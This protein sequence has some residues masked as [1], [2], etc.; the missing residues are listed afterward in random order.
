MAR[1]PG[2]QEILTLHEVAAYLR[3]HRSTIYRM[4]QNGQLPGAFRVGTDWRITRYALDK[5]I[6]DQLQVSGKPRLKR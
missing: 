1:K 4:I 6:Q 2:E 5:C 3:V